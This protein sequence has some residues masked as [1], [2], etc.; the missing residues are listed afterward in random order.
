LTVIIVGYIQ[1]FLYSRP[2]AANEAE[3]LILTGFDQNAELPV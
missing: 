1:G 2:V 3:I